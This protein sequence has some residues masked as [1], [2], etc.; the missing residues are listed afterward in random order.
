MLTKGMNVLYNNEVYIVYLVY[1]SGY[2]EIQKEKGSHLQ[3]ELVKAEELK[4]I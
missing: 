1:S 4:P 3:V 2:C